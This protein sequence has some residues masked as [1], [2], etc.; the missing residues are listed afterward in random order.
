MFCFDM[1]TCTDYT[2]Q[3][4]RPC[5]RLPVLNSY[6]EICKHQNVRS[7]ICVS[8]TFAYSKMASTEI[9]FSRKVNLT[10]LSNSQSYLPKYSRRTWP[11]K[12]S[13]QAENTPTCPQ[14]RCWPSAR[15]TWSRNCCVT[16]PIIRWSLDWTCCC[17]ACC[18]FGIV[19]SSRVN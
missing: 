12:N 8:A 11:Q 9:S 17:Y 1:C 15:K 19:L 10:D 2:V 3:Y 13:Y 7:I 18:M 14:P 5:Q 6:N 16:Q 4:L